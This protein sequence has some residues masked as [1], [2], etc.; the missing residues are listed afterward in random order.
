VGSRRGVWKVAVGALSIA[1]ACWL[2]SCGGEQDRPPEA[3]N[4]ILISVDTLRADHLGCY[5]YHRE[6]SPFLDS[7][8]REGVLFGQAI[9]P[10]PK[11]NTA[12]ASLLTGLY[13]SRH[14]VRTNSMPLGTIPTITSVLQEQGLVTAAFVSNWT[15]KPE[16]SGF[17]RHFDTYDYDFTTPELNRPHRFERSA[18]ETNERVFPWL[19]ER[20]STPFFLWIH[21]LDPHGPYR[22][23]VEYRRTFSHRERMMGPAEVVPHYQR[24]PEAYREGSLTDMADYIDQYD[25][26]IFYTDRQIEALIGKIGELGLLEKSLIIFTSDHGESLGQHDYHFEHGRELYDDSSRVPL[27][28]RFPLAEGLAG[29]RSDSLVSLLDIFPTI[30]DY[31][32]ADV[33]HAPGLDGVSLLPHLKRGES[34]RRE[35]FIE[36]HNGTVFDKMAIRTNGSKLILSR[37]R[38][39]CYD[40]EEDPG[41]LVPDGCDTAVLNDLSSRLQDFAAIARKDYTPAPQAVPDERDR[42]IL[43]SLGYVR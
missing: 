9:T 29:E 42:E 17:D 38:V 10:R 23:P 28:I 14:G 12:L 35:V 32:D 34:V 3:V 7:F 18:A 1:C 30:L 41:E 15:L 19:E 33:G 21:Y 5:G 20:D 13:P 27:V 16:F 26:E 40:L 22:P 43:R 24:L 25:N 37:D 11:T 31:F 6:T 4:V 8:T 36:R 39:E 2:F